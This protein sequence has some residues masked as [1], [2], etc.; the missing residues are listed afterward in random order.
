[1]NSEEQIHS[2]L[3]QIQQ[4]PYVIGIEVLA[5]DKPQDYC[6]IRFDLQVESPSHGLPAGMK[7]VERGLAFINLNNR[8]KAPD[9]YIRVDFPFVAHQ[10]IRRID[11]RDYKS[12]CLSRGSMADWWVGKTTINLIHTVK[13]WFDDAAAENLVKEDDPFEPLIADFTL[14][15]IEV[16]VDV[17]SNDEVL[18]SGM[19]NTSAIK[20]DIDGEELYSVGRSCSDSGDGIKT[21][22]WYQ[23]EVQKYYY[24]QRPDNTDEVITLFHNLGFEKERVRYWID[25][26]LKKSHKLL[27]V[28]G[29]RRPKEVLGRADSDE[30]VAFLIEKNSVKTHLVREKFNR[31]LAQRL[32]GMAEMPQ[33][34]VLIIGVGSF[35]SSVVENLIRSGVYELTLIDFDRLEP[36]NLARHNLD[37]RFLG[38]SKAT[39][40]AEKYN[41]I[42]GETICTGITQNVSQQDDAFFNQFDFIIDCS[43]SIGVQR[44]ISDLGIAKP[45]LSTYQ[46]ND[47]NATILLYVQDGSRQPISFTEIKM[48]SELKS[49]ENIKEWLTG[50][51]KS[52]N[53]GAG[54]RSASATIPFSQVQMGAAYVASKISSIFSGDKDGNAMLFEHNLKSLSK[55]K[56]TQIQANSEMFKAGNWCIYID[57]VAAE[58]IMTLAKQ[59]NTV[60]VGGILL[61]SI[62]RANEIVFVTDMLSSSDKGEASS[63]NRTASNF[64][65]QLIKIEKITSGSIH[66]VGE[67]HS[68]PNG[69]SCEMSI[70]DKQTMKSIAR[71][72]EQDRIPAICIITNGKDLSV[73]VVEEKL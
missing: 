21:L 11:G 26:E 62:D 49:N 29:V 51:A 33:K 40:L 50:S 68:H 69:S 73:H 24:A 31:T 57:F 10:N 72:L 64:K 32:S 59:N 25:K 39:S 12:I 60:E 30:W 28:L 67:W 53:I 8:L 66:Y 71:S 35:G 46:I 58:K 65:Y 1:M 9:V 63:F 41:N 54:C 42:F 7:E 3:E 19:L 23:K 48:I 52:V 27:L 16:D 56:C 47:G 4:L 36:H 6:T 44:Y 43:A 18:V 37:E 70:T 45:I 17:F 22:V 15:P 2:E 55:I 5:S 20:N 14:P 13:C 38:K 34:K 61:G